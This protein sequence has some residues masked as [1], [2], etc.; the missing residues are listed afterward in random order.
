MNSFF[1][2]RCILQHFLSSH[3]LFIITRNDINSTVQSSTRTPVHNVILFIDTSTMLDNQAHSVI[4]QPCLATHHAD[5]AN[6]SDGL[7]WVS[8]L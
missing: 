7:A 1:R 3:D 5:R 2:I 6:V 8:G 4:E